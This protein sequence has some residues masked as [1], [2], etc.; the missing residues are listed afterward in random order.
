M[1]FDFEKKAIFEN[2]CKIRLHIFKDERLANLLYHRFILLAT[3]CLK[4]IKCVMLVLLHKVIVH[5]T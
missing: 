5:K 3:C 2:V 1:D 4:I